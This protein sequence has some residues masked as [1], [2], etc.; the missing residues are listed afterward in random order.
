MTRTASAASPSTWRI[1]AAF[2]AV[3]TIWGSTYLGIRFAVE[4]IP[5][6]LMA[7]SRFLVAGAI[8]YAWMR[9]SGNPAPTRVHWRN[10]AIIGG[11]LLVGGNGLLSW[12]EQTVPS[13]FAAL[14]VATVPVW[15]VLLQWLSGRGARPSV[16]IAIG[17]VLGL[18]GIALLIGPA[19]LTS[20]NRI[21]PFGILALVLEAILW[22]IGS[23]YGHRAELPKAS[24]LGTGMEMFTAG[25]VL[26]LVATLTGE[27]GQLAPDHV[28]VRSLIA[29]GYLLVFGSLVGFSAYTWLVRVTPPALSS[30]FAF[31]NPVVAVFLGWALAGEALTPQT[32]LAAAVIIAA[33]VTITLSQSKTSAPEPEAVASPAP[34]E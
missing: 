23:L 25:A 6:F 14:V 32:L 29:V 5:P 13:G 27:W 31:V 28:S 1:V 12:A 4:T 8:L 2:A 22:S 30:T 7:G 16:G 26:L 17:L 34:G 33:V 10:A 19:E 3:Y 20:A 21:N 24:L 9:A 11:F 18:I 15:T